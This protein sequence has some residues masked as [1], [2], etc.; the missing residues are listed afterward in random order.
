M[1]TSQRERLER[2]F[3]NASRFMWGV[4]PGDKRA[5][6]LQLRTLL[7]ELGE[8]S[9]LVPDDKKATYAMVIE[10]LVTKIG[11]ERILTQIV[12]GEVRRQFTGRS[13]ALGFLRAH[14][15][16]GTLPRWQTLQSLRAP[17]TIRQR[18]IQAV[19]SPQDTPAK[20]QQT[21]DVLDAF[22][23]VNTQYNYVHGWTVFAGLWFEEIEPLLK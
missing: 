5:V 7:E 22:V 6:F 14:W 15:M 8:E 19:G 20:R 1:D 3:R 16:S 17:Q 12:A 4:I 10:N 2:Y 18:L 13:P 21:S 9:T 11:I 23:E